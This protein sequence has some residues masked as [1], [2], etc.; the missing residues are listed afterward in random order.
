MLPK[1]MKVQTKANGDYSY[2]DF[3]FYTKESIYA[4]QKNIVFLDF[5]CRKNWP[6]TVVPDPEDIIL[7]KL[8]SFV[9]Q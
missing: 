8:L 2:P 9:Q 7:R 5:F 1:S 4:N 3:L 6:G